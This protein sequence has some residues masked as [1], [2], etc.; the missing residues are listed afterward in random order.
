VGDA[1]ATSYINSQMGV[2]VSGPNELWITADSI[3][4]TVGDA[5][6]DLSPEAIGGALTTFG[7]GVTCVPAAMPGC[8]EPWSALC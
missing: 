1:F 8:L 6:G 4:D 2:P 3:K 7:L 5:L